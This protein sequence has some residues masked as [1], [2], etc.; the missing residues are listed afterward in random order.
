LDHVV[1]PFGTTV[2]KEV[3]KE[4][5]KSEK[6]GD[7]WWEKGNLKMVAIAPRAPKEGPKNKKKLKKSRGNVFKTLRGE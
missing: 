4:V 6:Y 1:K 5:E 3:K 7:T 2:K